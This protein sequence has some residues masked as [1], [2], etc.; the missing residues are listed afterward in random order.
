VVTRS[1]RKSDCFA[2]WKGKEILVLLS[3][4]KIDASAKMENRFFINYYETDS[5]R[6][7]PIKLRSIQID[8]NTKIKL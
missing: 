8:E 6:A 2:I 4:V 3:D 5:S 1:F 7:L